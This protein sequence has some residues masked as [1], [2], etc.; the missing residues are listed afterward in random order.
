VPYQGLASLENYDFLSPDLGWVNSPQ[1]FGLFP[2]A[3]PYTAFKEQLAKF[4][5][6]GGEK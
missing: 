4:Q 3:I 1:S 6:E 5:E 2:D